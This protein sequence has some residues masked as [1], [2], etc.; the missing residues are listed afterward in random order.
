MQATRT[1][2]RDSIEKIQ[3]ILSFK[4]VMFKTKQTRL[5]REV[6]P[7]QT[8]ALINK[9]EK[10]QAIKIHTFESVWW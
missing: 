5:L 7:Q 1:V 2:T 3:P 4:A 9:S 6:K 8:D 10:K